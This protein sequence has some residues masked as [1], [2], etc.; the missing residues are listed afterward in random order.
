MSGAR[1]GL[2]QGLAENGW[3]GNEVLQ[4][5]LQWR[6]PPA[7]RGGRQGRLYYGTQV[8]SRPPSFTLFVNDPKLFS[9]P[10]RAEMI[11]NKSAQP[12]YEY[13]CHEGNHALPGILVGMALELDT[14]LEADGE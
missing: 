1:R 5:A 3:L 14:A 2:C 10:W 11:F 8:A 6:S 4:E 13:A 7:T 9:Q 12:A